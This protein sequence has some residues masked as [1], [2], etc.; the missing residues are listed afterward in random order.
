MPMTREWSR[1]SL[2]FL[3]VVALIGT[4]L[5]SVAF[6]QVPFEYVNLLHAHSHVAF[7][8]WVYTAMILLLT[9]TYLS[10]E[11]GKR[12][13][14]DLQ[15]VLTVIVVV[16]ILISFALQGYAFYSILFST[17]FQ[18]LNYWFIF[19]FFKD[20]KK[21]D[22]HANGD[23]SLRFVKAGLWF[24]LLSTLLPV[25]IGLLSARG[26]GGSE[27]YRSLVYTFLHLQYNGWFLFVVL[28]LFYR[29]LDLNSWS[30]D[31]RHASRFY[32]LLAFAV[33]PSISLS[34]LG[35]EFSGY[36][37][38]VAYA[39]SAL[40][41]GAFV[42]FIRGLPKQWYSAL[43]QKNF[44]FRGYL[45]AF[46]LSFV[47]K[48]ILQTLSVLPPFQS[49]ASYNKF[50]IIAYL[51]LSLIGSISFLL[52]ALFVELKWLLTTG[53]FR[54]GSVLLISGFAF[55]ETLLVLAG[56]G[57]YYNGLFLSLG[58]GAMALGVLL[59]VLNGRGRRKTGLLP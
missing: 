42:F 9:K 33:I 39:S 58:S 22:F 12:G 49:Y 17:L 51:H 19:R 45:L 27:A 4:L 56:L 31:K 55:T 14:Y 6:V 53:L 24:G 46:I 28:G 47:I 26:E 41:G 34:L 40:L 54:V 30:Y 50:I 10:D 13:R 18:L 37:M 1:I 48:M 5:R 16:G 15:F 35:M 8:G 36:L 2:F 52:L 43:R 57:W 7:Q 20:V 25:G 32:Y 23:L 59:M 11:Q 38:P 3:F 44:W 29:F 21:T